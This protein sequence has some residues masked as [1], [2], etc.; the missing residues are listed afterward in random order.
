MFKLW[1]FRLNIFLQYSVIFVISCG[2]FHP[3]TVPARQCN[4]SDDLNN[5]VAD[6]KEPVEAMENKRDM[7]L[8]PVK[9]IIVHLHIKNISFHI[10]LHLY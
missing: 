6:S 2:T 7:F 4:S 5:T 3:V 9:G 1:P 10:L 8:L